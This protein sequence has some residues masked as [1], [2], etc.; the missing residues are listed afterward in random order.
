MSEASIFDRAHDAL[1]V[2][3]LVG[4]KS[5]AGWARLKGKTPCPICSG[6]GDFSFTRAKWKCHRSG[7]RGSALDLQALLWG[8]DAFE[9]ACRV[10]NLD[11]DEQRKLYGRGRSERSERP[12][13]SAKGRARPVVTTAAAIDGDVAAVIAHVK[14][15]LRL[16]NGSVLERYLAAR[17][18]P[19]AWAAQIWFCP[20]APYESDALYGRGRSFPAMVCFPE[21]DGARTGGVHLTYLREDGRGKAPVR[22]REPAKK[23][24][25]PQ[26]DAHGRA[27]GL[28]LIAPQDGGLLCVAEG[29]ENA[30][31]CAFA[32]GPG[33]GAFAAGSLDRLQG[34][35][36]LNRW[37]QTDWRA[38]APA[39]DRPAAT[40]RHKGPV[41]I[42]VDADMSALV[43]QRGTRFER[44]I[45]PE[46]RA[47]V[48]GL[49]AGHWWRKAGATEIRVLTP[50]NGKDAND[51]IRERAA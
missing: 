16:G 20:D 51:V 12:R 26:L 14:R 23:M 22:D 48:S 3:Q 39:D 27:G 19:S 46:R 17:G 1:D 4:G 34:G 31:S 35:M 42:C 24:W 33:A 43:L 40:M 10:L 32:A 50:P 21:V 47:Q 29:I 49:L 13:A 36:A 18:L 45:A 2:G 41:L 8:V 37:G 30:L 44:T 5:G 15:Q 28:K 9:A 7:E 25:G 11:A 6:I 38:P